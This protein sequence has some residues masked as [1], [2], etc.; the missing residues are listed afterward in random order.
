VPPS[1][2]TYK[3]RG[4]LE[5]GSP[6]WARERDWEGLL[7]VGVGTLFLVR[8]F[9]LRKDEEGRDQ[10]LAPLGY[11][12]VRGGMPPA[13]A[14]R[15]QLS[16]PCLPYPDR[17]WA[18]AR[19]QQSWPSL[20]PAS[21]PSAPSDGFFTSIRDCCSLWLAEWDSGPG[22]WAAVWPWPGHSPSQPQLPPL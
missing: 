1:M 19:S 22:H 18:G 12:W 21:Q 16:Q 14:L 3:V 11:F 9:P 13:P 2:R 5:E 7:I 17:P 15:L 4:R 10:L 6:A 8:L 20:P